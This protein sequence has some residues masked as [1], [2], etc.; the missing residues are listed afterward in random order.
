MNQLQTRGIVLSRTDF[1]EADR[2]LTVLT[3]QHGKLRLMAKGVRRVKSKLAGGIELF[4]V[5]D[6]TYISGRGEIGTLISSRLDKH[7][8]NIVKKLDRVQFGY[9]LLK[10]L[11]KVTEDA[12]EPDYFDLAQ[13]ALIALDNDKIDLS[14][15]EAWFKAQLLKMSGHA[16]N[17]RTDIHGEKLSGDEYYNFD[18]DA[19]AFNSHPQGG[20]RP[21]DIKVLR[22]LFGDHTPHGLNSVEG[23]EKTLNQTKPLLASMTATYL[24]L[25]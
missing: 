7:Y 8:G 5:S 24:R 9:E 25:D 12:P 4:S 23:L 17:L 21:N 2:I 22:L 14:L 10:Q 20:F 16:P 13:Q 6:L 15:I 3:R 1:G 18:F 11:N 19:M